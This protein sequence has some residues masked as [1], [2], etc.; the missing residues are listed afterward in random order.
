MLAEKE[1][2]RQAAIR[3]KRI[4][5]LRK[6]YIAKIAAKVRENW[7]TSSRIHPKASCTLVITQNSKGRVLSVKVTKCN[8][9]ATR[10]FKVDAERAVYRTGTL[11][12]PP[13]R[14]VFERT[15]RFIF[16]P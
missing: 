4:Q 1:K 9:Y 7:R 13:D 8:R 14:S 12:A 5:E 15:I 10:Q 3:K 16:K 2:K 6:L 11:P